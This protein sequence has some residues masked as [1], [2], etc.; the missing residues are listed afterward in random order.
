MKKV[1]QIQSEKERIE[2]IH[3]FQSAKTF[4]E[5]IQLEFQLDSRIERIEYE[6]NEEQYEKANNC[7]ETQIGKAERSYDE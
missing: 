5:S 2:W 7:V 3:S 4:N 6:R 1:G